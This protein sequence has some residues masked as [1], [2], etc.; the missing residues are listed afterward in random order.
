MPASPLI[1]RWRTLAALT[2]ARTAM[3]FQ[4]Q[5]I[6]AVSPFLG[7]DIGLDNAQLGWLIGLYLLPGIAFAL[8]GGLLAARFGDR[9]MTLAGLALM[10]FGGIVIALA[11]SYGLANAGRILSGAGGAILNVVLTKMIADT[12]EPRERVLA[13]SILINAWPIGIGIALVTVG[14]L[15]ALAGWRVGV[16]TGALFA[17]LGWLAVVTT[18]SKGPGQTNVLAGIGLR[19]I[20][21]SEWRLLAIGSLPW[22]LFNAA[23]QIVM[24][25]LPA[26][27]L[28][29]G[30]SIAEAGAMAGLNAFLVVVSV[31]TG[32]IVL[33]RIR[34]RGLV[35]LISILVWAT[36][37]IALSLGATPLLCIVVGGL[38]AGIPASAFVTLPSEFLR[39]QSR[40]AGMGV[41]YS[42]Y[43]VGCAILPAIAG[44]AFDATG[45]ATS[46][47]WLAALAALAS[48]AAYGAFRFEQKR[49]GIIQR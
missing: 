36:S 47:L 43:Y 1:H 24:S 49:I 31:A 37:L 27:F 3:G 42:V 12:F 32:G 7:K 20:S 28:G 46:T 4:F 18:V 40:A 10:T 21:R 35:C 8:P 9:R 33:E 13:M 48:V 14:P 25:F 17:L 22:L 6:A 26:V 16:A 5:T 41:F 2:F 23:F 29:R 15:A 38:A 30:S 44:A 45:K 11:D 19:I 39:P 34:A